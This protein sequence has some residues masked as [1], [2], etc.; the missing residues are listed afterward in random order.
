MQTRNRATQAARDFPKKWF[1]SEDAAAHADQVSAEAMV[2]LLLA[3]GKVEV[4]SKDKYAQ[5]PLWRAS[6][7]GHEAV[8]KL[9][10]ATGGRLEG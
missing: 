1:E 9:L 5:T 6:V 2:K 10:F 7:N 4:N 8:V 3:T